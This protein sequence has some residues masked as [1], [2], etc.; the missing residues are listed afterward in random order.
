MALK[1]MVAT[2]D[3]LNAATD[4][5]DAGGSELRIYDGTAPTTLEIGITGQQLLVTCLMDVTTPVQGASADSGQ[6][7]ALCNPISDGIVAIGSTCTF[8]R[9]VDSAGTA[10][11][12][13][14]AGI[15]GGGAELT[16]ADPVFQVGGNVSIDD[17]FALTL[18][19]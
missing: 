1:S 6:A 11:F 14:S 8:W 19:L 9:M 12:Q 7:K 15:T 3:A 13:G 16:F 17:N 5:L 10:V 18:G 2:I 4:D